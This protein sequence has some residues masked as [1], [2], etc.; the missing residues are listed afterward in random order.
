MGPAGCGK[1]TVGRAL[2]RRLGGIFLDADDYHPERNLAR[3]R[4]GDALTDADRWP[5][6]A[7]VAEALD[8][9][10]QPGQPVVVACSALKRAYRHA[11]G[12]PGDHRIVVEL[13]LPREVLARRLAERREHF[14]DAGLLDSQLADLEPA[15]EGVAL[16]ADA[17]VETLVARILLCLSD[18]Q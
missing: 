1:T 11:L 6:L 13:R 3:M 5:W 7:A 8:G 10:E 4:R 2:A 16:A 17:P 14:F 9:A 15:D 12:F 18:N